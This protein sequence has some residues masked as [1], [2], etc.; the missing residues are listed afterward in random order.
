MA[1][2]GERSPEL[3]FEPAHIGIVACSV[4]GAALCYRTIVLESE[5][6]LGGYRHP[7]ITLDNLPLDGY[8]TA[9]D[10]NELPA[11][12]D[13]LRRSMGTLAQAGAAFGICPDNSV[14]LALPYAGTTVLPMLHI[15]DVVADHAAK[16]GY[17]RVGVLG[18]RVT[19]ESSLYADA[20]R[21]HTIEAVSPDAADARI[22]DDLIRRELVRGL[23][24]STAR[25]SFQK[26]IDA[27]RRRKCDAV[28]LGCTEIP[29]LIEPDDSILPVLDS[30][31]LLAKAALRRALERDQHPPRLATLPS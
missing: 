1:S 31:R 30:T 3:G 13:L 15:A 24:T 26:V 8:M 21:I 12:G 29:L 6:L 27:L 2:P 18:M 9:L 5:K 25:R 23:F 16:Q 4:E 14:H 10:H 22:V 11:A 28:V 20:L 19:M 7:R 17:H